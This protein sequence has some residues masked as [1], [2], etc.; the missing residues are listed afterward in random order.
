TCPAALSGAYEY[1]HLIVPVSSA[2]PDKAY[3]TQYNATI[4]STVST[5]F[6]FD[7]PAS[8]AGKTCTLV[9]LFPKQSQL[10]TSAFT[11]NGK[12]GIDISRLSSPATAGTTFNSVPSA[13]KVGSIANVMAGNSYTILSRACPAGTR[14]GY[15]V[16]STNGLELE[17]FEDWNPSPIGL[18]VTVC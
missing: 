2:S 14:V 13:S 17:F 10:E 11:F 1:P 15:E 7:Y 3:G 9:F 4:S 8:Y 12:G 18:F 5:L 16:S 6:N